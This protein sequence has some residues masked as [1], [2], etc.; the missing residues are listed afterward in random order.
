[1]SQ[2]NFAALMGV[3][4]K[5]GKITVSRWESGRIRPQ[6]IFLKKFM[7]IQNEYDNSNS[8]ESVQY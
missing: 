3:K 7:E 8:K 5:Q 4:N 2:R 1:L 6:N